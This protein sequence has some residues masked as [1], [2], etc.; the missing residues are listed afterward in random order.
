MVGR[1][2]YSDR[3]LKILFGLAQGS[4]MFPNC[5]QPCLLPNAADDYDIVGQISHIYAYSPGGPRGNPKALNKKQLNHHSNLLLLCNIHH[6]VVDSPGNK[7]IYTADVLFAWKQERQK[8]IT[9]RT[10]SLVPEVT[11]KELNDVVDAILANPL[12]PNNNFVATPPEE[13]MAKND[14]TNE[15]LRF[16]IFGYGKALEV[17]EF[18]NSR[19][20]EDSTF[21]ERLK[22]G[23]V[24]E[25]NRL[26]EAGLRGDDLFTALHRFTYGYNDDLI[27]RAAGLSVLVYLFQKC[28]I[29]AP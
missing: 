12:A 20:R 21:P 6:P 19:A 11:F 25:Y 23:F 26:S 9:D 2:G 29:F 13:K 1:E 3:T 5:S 24:A 14:L 17:E 4:C 7:T 27:R 8:W 18:V 28:E 16:I 15:T 10:M 22:S